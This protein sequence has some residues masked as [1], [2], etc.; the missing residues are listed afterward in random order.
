MLIIPCLC[1]ASKRFN[2]HGH[3]IDFRQQIFIKV[4][5]LVVYDKPKACLSTTSFIFKKIDAHCLGLVVPKSVPKLTPLNN[6]H[7]HPTLAST[8][9]KALYHGALL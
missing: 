3:L 7:T 1:K 6:L 2:G 8:H 9:G 5:D 4:W